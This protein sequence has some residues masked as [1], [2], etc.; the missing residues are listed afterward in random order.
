MYIFLLIMQALVAQRKRDICIKAWPFCRPPACLWPCAWPFFKPHILLGFVSSTWLAQGHGIGFISSHIHLVEP[1]LKAQQILFTKALGQLCVFGSMAAR[2]S[3]CCHAAY[4]RF[5]PVC[6][7]SLG[8][9]VFAHLSQ[10]VCPVKFGY[11]LEQA[12]LCDMSLQPNI[13]L[14]ASLHGMQSCIRLILCHEKVCIC[15]DVIEHGQVM[16]T[17]CYMAF[18]QASCLF[19]LI[20]GH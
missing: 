17:F 9:L 7:E 6:P 5:L 2:M 13:M 4:P 14:Q 18:F 16:K 10:M 15:N 3:H 1:E 12:V 19:G 11:Q 20:P 8:I